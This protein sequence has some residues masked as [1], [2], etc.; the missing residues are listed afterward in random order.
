MILADRPG[1]E[2]RGLIMASES[3][4]L[5]ITDRQLHTVDVGSDSMRTETVPGFR[6][7]GRIL[8]GRGR[9]LVRYGPDRNL[10][11]TETLLMVWDD[12]N[13]N[14]GVL[15]KLPRELWHLVADRSG[16]LWM[17]DEYIVYLLPRAAVMRLLADAGFD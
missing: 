17:A 6:R 13:E 15:A 3:R 9:A 8:G 1:A 12:T 11:L 4:L 16:N 7:F 5:C 10:I 14:V 2:V